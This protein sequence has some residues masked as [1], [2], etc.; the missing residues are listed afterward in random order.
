LA[1]A[2]A[3]SILAGCGVVSIGSEVKEFSP[4]DYCVDTMRRALPEA[5]FDI[6]KQTS[7]ADDLAG[8]TVVVTATRTDAPASALVNADVAATC[9]FDHDMLVDFHWTKS[10]LK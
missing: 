1:A 4:S 8:T 2:L 9:R 3:A 7:A 6:T 5:D 10:P